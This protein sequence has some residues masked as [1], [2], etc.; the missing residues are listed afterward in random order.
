MLESGEI[1]LDNE[2]HKHCISW[3]IIQVANEGIKLFIS[4]WNQHTIPGAI[5]YF[6]H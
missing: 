4:S 2:L 5:K 6:I 3:F 1:S